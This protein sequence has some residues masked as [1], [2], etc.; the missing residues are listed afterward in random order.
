MGKRSAILLCISITSVIILTGGLFLPA[1]F[2]PAGI[3]ETEWWRTGWGFVGIC[4]GFLLFLPFISKKK[5][6]DLCWQKA[7]TGILLLLGAK[8]AGVGLLQLFDF[9]PSQHSRYAF[10]GSFYNPGPYCGFLAVVFPIAFHEFLKSHKSIS[11]SYLNRV[12]NSVTGLICL[13]LLAMIAAGTSRAAWC[14]VLVSAVWIYCHSLNDFDLRSWLYRHRKLAGILTTVALAACI[15]I[16][17]LK[18]DSALGRLFIWKISSFCIFDN[19]LTGNGNFEYAYGVSQENYFAH[20]DYAEWEERV[21]GC[22]Q[23]AFNEY[24]QIAVEHGIPMLAILL[25]LLF[26]CFRKGIRNGQIAACGG[27]LSFSVFAFFSYPMEFPAFAIVLFLLLASC[28]IDGR[29]R[30]YL[31]LATTGGVA[32]FSILTHNTHEE[33]TTWNECHAIYQQGAYESSR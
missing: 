22:P 7:I 24:I 2:Q 19:P 11:K 25:L 3:M 15:G 32:G 27:L 1:P 10:T 9:L 4:A 29:I 30:T 6:P 16:F 12:Y 31:L 23:Y 28:C 13:L 20:A 8:E 33:V 18:K 17:L 26:L 14:A 21:A 5:S